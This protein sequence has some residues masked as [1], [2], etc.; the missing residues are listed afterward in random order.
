MVFIACKV[1]AVIHVFEY[2]CHSIACHGDA[3]EGFNEWYTGLE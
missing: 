3:E 1:C 2:M